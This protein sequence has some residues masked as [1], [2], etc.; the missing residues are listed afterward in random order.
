MNIMLDK[1][2]TEEQVR[3]QL[4]AKFMTLVSISVVVSF[5][6]I[7]HSSR[8]DIWSQLVW[9]CLLSFPR[10]IRLVIPPSCDPCESCVA[11]ITQIGSH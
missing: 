9:T 4:A 5:H 10:I 7:T 6:F 3:L 2:L 11:L 1:G 8:P